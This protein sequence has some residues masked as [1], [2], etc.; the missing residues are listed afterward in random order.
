MTSS[1]ETH[2]YLIGSRSW[3]RK[4]HRYLTPPLRRRPLFLPDRSYIVRNNIGENLYSTGSCKIGLHGIRGEVPYFRPDPTKKR[5]GVDVTFIP[6]M[7]V[8]R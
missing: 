4:K 8:Q 5:H 7:Y 1:Q 3:K 2:L 6:S